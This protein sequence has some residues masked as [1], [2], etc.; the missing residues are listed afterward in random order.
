MKKLLPAIKKHFAACLIMAACLVNGFFVFGDFGIAWDEPNQHDIGQKTYDYVRGWDK[1]L[2]DFKNRDYGVAVEMPLILLEKSFGLKDSRS[3]YRMRHLVIHLFFLF[4]AL[5]FYILIW[6]LHKNRMVAV[7]GLI[8]LLLSP[9]IFAQSF[10]NSKDIPF[11]CMF[12]LCFLL[13]A[14]SFRDRKFRHF[15]LFGI[16][17][18][19]LINIRIMGVIVPG[20]VTALVALDLIKGHGRKEILLNYGIY[21]LMAVAV[22]YVSWPWLWED[23]AGRFRIAFA[24]MSK[25]RWNNNVLFNGEFV[26]AS[27]V[28]WTYI[29]RW[30]GLT[31]PVAYLLLGFT[32]FFV[33]AV[34][35]FR[36][37]GS[38]LDNNPER[39][40]LVHLA[41]FAGP[42]FA[43]IVLHSVL[44]DGWRQMYFIYP[45]F[46]LM[47]VYG[48]SSLLKSRIF[49]SLWLKIMLASLLILSFAGTA[50][51]MITSHPFEDV[52]F[53][54]LLSKDDQYLRKTYELDYW[55]TSYKQALEYIAANDTS[56]VLNIRVA[57]LPGEFN[58]MILRPEVRKRIHYV[59][60]DE[61]AGYFIT[62]YR[63]HPQNYPYPENKK[64]FNIKVRNS[65]ICSAWKL[66]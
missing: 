38:F 20:I 30:F 17:T 61:Q 15:V 28:G 63:W 54:I 19:L 8:M 21:L 42:V 16:V 31:T 33:L 14:V 9:R 66:K 10:Y 60:T 13:F 50:F 53:N 52:Y 40:H 43:V 44:Y 1:G 58:A 5:F 29:P 37:P 65:D 62:N 51:T 24:N 22:L 3:I 18:G 23:P 39:N 36:R 45:A 48:F 56:S 59:E 25:F 49:S 55:G 11:M 34:R 12:I 27:D 47:A 26:S 35:F 7:A 32:G 57:N 46:L 6:K 2:N 4:S 64:I 41:C